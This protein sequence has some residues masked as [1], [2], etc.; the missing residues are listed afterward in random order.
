LLGLITEG[1][2]SLI[3]QKSLKQ[4]IPF[5]PYLATGGLILLFFEKSIINFLLF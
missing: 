2:K 3:L 4:P 1:I 5:R